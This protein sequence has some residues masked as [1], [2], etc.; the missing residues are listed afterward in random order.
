MN[1]Q[2]YIIEKKTFYNIHFDTH[3]NKHQI[4]IRPPENLRNE[5]S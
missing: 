3:G 4:D 1:I 5:V 2:Q